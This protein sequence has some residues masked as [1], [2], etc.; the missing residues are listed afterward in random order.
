MLKRFLLLLTTT[1]FALHV[2]AQVEI[3]SVRKE[4][5]KAESDS[6]RA[7]LLGV[8]AWELKFSRQEEAIQLAKEEIR[9]AEKNTLL[10]YLADG[11]RTLGFVLILQTHLKEG[12]AAYNQCLIYARKSGNKLYEAS[13][14]SMIAGMYQ[15]KGDFD[16]SLNYYLKGLEVAEQTD[17]HRL[18]A[19]LCNN[20]ASL[21]ADAGHN[22]SESLPYFEKALQHVTIIQNWSFAGMI[23]ANIAVE[24]HRNGNMSKCNAYI[25]RAINYAS[26]S[27]ATD[28]DY[29]TIKYETGNIYL[30][31]EKYK[32]AEEY[33]Q[34]SLR[35]LDSLQM[36]DNALRP[37][38]ALSQLYLKLSQ[39]KKAKTYATRLLN[40]AQKQQA[41]LFIGEA[42]KTLANI[43]R[44]EK[45]Y[46][47]A[48]NYLELANQWN[49][50]VFNE[51]R[52]R[53]IA[54][55]QAQSLLQQHELEMKLN[56]KHGRNEN[57]ILKAKNKSLRNEKILAII[58][59]MA[60]LLIGF[61]LFRGYTHKNK[62]NKELEKQKL[63]ILNQ[64]VEKDTLIRE[65]HH[66]VKNNLQIV[67]SL[68][69]LQSN[70]MEDKN[71]IEALRESHNRVKTIS[72]LHQKLYA[73]DVLS[74]IPLN[75]YILQLWNHL[76]T[77]YKADHAEL[78]TTIQPE[79]LQLDMETAIPIGLILNELITNALKY[80]LPDNQLKTIITI[81]LSQ[82]DTG[83]Y[84]LT[85]S[86]NG[87]GMPGDFNAEQS[88]SLGIRILKELTRQLR[89][90]ITYSSHTGAVFTIH[91]PGTELRKNIS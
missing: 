22:A 86:D 69:N 39:T 56:V 61:F 60:L 13:C 1:I 34:T 76:R 87:Q 59:C 47:K 24:H 51:S 19:V 18:I 80:A 50:S 8:L 11:Y 74:A 6:A 40:D 89:G 32:I 64:S 54:N 7:R 71:A 16:Q 36:P 9:L 43:A 2:V 73:F 17:N 20:T 57:E 37:L 44:A 41:K 14:L 65:I 5:A 58:L 33:L 77:V 83:F 26:K 84:N 21:L 72:L 46:P 48:L 66:R 3:E 55:A 49:D 79:N 53:G 88:T 23:C 28:Y 29:A 67:S 91:F 90:A 10:N 35:V 4:L 70:S 81:S 38:S 42:Y 27:N 25:D 82:L 85:V 78:K 52:E 31:T 12:L 68:L 62:Q 75:E 15:D 63:I 30:K 45:D